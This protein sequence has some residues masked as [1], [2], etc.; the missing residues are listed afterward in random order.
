MYTLTLGPHAANFNDVVKAISSELRQLD[1]RVDLEVGGTSIRL[2]AF[3]ICVTGDML[4]QNVHAGV[5]GPT[6]EMSCRFCLATAKDRADMRFDFI[7]HGRYPLKD[8]I[9]RK[10]MNSTRTQAAAEKLRRNYDLS[11]DKSPILQFSPA[12][13]ITTFFPTN[14]AHSE[15]KS[16]GC[17]MMETF[18]AM[19][20]PAGQ[21]EYCQIFLHFPVPSGWTAIQAPLH[22]LKS[23][24]IQEYEKVSIINP[25]LL[26]LYLEP[27]WILDK[28]RR[29]LAIVFLSKDVN[30]S[31]ADINFIIKAFALIAKSNCLLT[32]Q[33]AGASNKDR[34]Y[35]AVIQGRET[36]Q[37][38][39]S[40]LIMGTGVRN[41]DAARVNMS[42][43]GTPAVIPGR[44]RKTFKHS[45]ELERKTGWPNIHIGL[46]YRKVV[47][48]YGC[49]GNVTVLT[50]ENKHRVYKD[51]VT[52][53]NK[54]NVEKTLLRQE[55]LRLTL[56]LVLDGAFPEKPRLKE[57]LTEAS[58]LC[59]TSIKTFYSSEME[60]D[61]EK[62]D[63][64][65]IRDDGHIDPCARVALTSTQGTRR[66][67]VENAKISYIN[68]TFISELQNAYK[69]RRR[70]AIKHGDFVELV[71]GNYGMIF[72]VFTHTGAKT[73]CIFLAIVSFEEV[74]RDV[75]LEVL[76]LR[77]KA[78][79]RIIVGMP[80]VA[81]GALYTIPIQ[82]PAHSLKRRAWE[83]KDEPEL[84]IQ[85]EDEWLYQ[86]WTVDFM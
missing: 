82:G 26:R 67:G 30:P 59:P 2:I 24:Q 49:A 16:S 35:A 6:G 47:E 13:N 77:R 4:Q 58:V 20:T 29:A 44:E 37:K 43:E 81:S 61:E 55:S 9:V 28:V 56:A 45:K 48:E 86:K 38:L 53:T 31:D 17:M 71:D 60:K 27:H 72:T 83:L 40:A 66:L 75:L 7:A 84:R 12:V 15:L 51:L 78:G 64:A 74:R 85:E 41:A 62:M 10:K 39:L 63:S 73:A 3:P 80:M 8:E 34:V 42:R 76:I 1:S 22:H 21:R 11:I 46:H 54:K 14:A 36:Y 65:W 25:I 79:G 33:I 5:P 57:K 18:L 32:K 50:G 52:R 68:K 19:M 23:F 69:R 70:T